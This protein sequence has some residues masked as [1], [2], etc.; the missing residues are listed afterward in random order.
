MLDLIGILAA[1][2]SLLIALLY[3][4]QRHL[5]YHPLK[6]IAAPGQYGL[7]QFSEHHAATADHESIQLWHHEAR[8]G[9]PTI[10]YFHGNAGNMGERAAIYDALSRQGFG[11]LGVSYRGY[12]EST[13][14]PSEAGLYTDARTAIAFWREHTG[15]SYDRII[16]YGESLGTGVAVQMA[17]EYEVGGLILQAPYI[18]VAA[19]AAE[20][21][22]FI[23]VRLMIKDKYLS[24]RK[25]GRVKAPLLLFHGE[26]DDIIPIAHG[27]VVLEAATA[28]KQAVFFPETGHNDFDTILLAQHVLDF[29][30]KHNLIKDKL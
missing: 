24:I 6:A 29:A 19:R 3:C 17:L 21:Y 30:R 26:Q 2:Y 18:S 13:G 8:E 10:I 15:Q 11:V 16:L 5:I 1:L 7:E 28:P 25:I 12:G 14:A 23:P 22:P 20:M 27:K 4:F 9:F